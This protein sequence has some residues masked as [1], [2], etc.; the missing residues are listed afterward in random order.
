MADAFNYAVN[1]S[2]MVEVSAVYA[3]GRG[4]ESCTGIFLEF[5]LSRYLPCGSQFMLSKF[6]CNTLGWN[7]VPSFL[8]IIFS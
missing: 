7:A 8:Y 4:F 2:R 1:L 6:N 3:E 5:F